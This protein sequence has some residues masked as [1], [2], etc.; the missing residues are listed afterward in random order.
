MNIPIFIICLQIQF[1]Q[2]NCY[3]L[4]SPIVSVIATF[5]FQRCTYELFLFSV[6]ENLWKIGHFV[7]LGCWIAHVLLFVSLSIFC[8]K[9]VFSN[10]L[11]L[12]LNILWLP[13]KKKTKKCVC[14]KG[15]MALY[16]LKARSMKTEIY[17]L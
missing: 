7:N 14:N 13:P 3:S 10:N 15:E 17:K 8:H 2:K 9:L 16:K 11:K 12:G 4:K 1:K 5:L 6:L